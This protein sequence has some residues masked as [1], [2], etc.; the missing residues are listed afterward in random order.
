MLPCRSYNILIGFVGTFS[1]LPWMGLRKSTWVNWEKTGKPLAQGGLGIHSI[2]ETN[3]A[4]LS[5]WLWMFRTE[6]D[7]LW[8][9]VI[10]AKYKTT[11]SGWDTILS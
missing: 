3:R 7:A 6:L 9:R 5:K 10:A 1:S 8:R 11:T 4:L 2:K